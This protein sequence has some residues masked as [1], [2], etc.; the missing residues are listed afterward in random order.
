[1]KFIGSVNIIL[2]SRCIYEQIA[3]HPKTQ[4]GKRV[5]QSVWFVCEM[6]VFIS[7]S[8]HPPALTVKITFPSANSILPNL[9]RHTNRNN[10]FSKEIT[11]VSIL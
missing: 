4:L 5:N 11:A 10:L 2:I 1:M 9:S 7:F 3:L 8:V 6:F